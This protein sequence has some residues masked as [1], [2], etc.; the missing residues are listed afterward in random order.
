MS[1]MPDTSDNIDEKLAVIRHILLHG[2]R[3]R[4]E[5]LEN[6]I[7]DTNLLSEHVNPI[8]DNKITDIKNDFSN[9]FGTEVGLEFERKLL[10]SEDLLLTVLSPMMGKMIRK[11]ISIEIKKLQ[12]KID[13]QVK[14]SF[15]FKRYYHIIRAKVFGIESSALFLADLDDFKTKLQ[16]VFAIQISG[17]VIASARS[18]DSKSGDGDIFS[19]MLTAIKFFGEDSFKRK[20]GQKQELEFIEYESQKIF[21]QNHHNYYFAAVLNGSLNNSEKEKLASQLMEFADKEKKLNLPEISPE[22]CKYLSE[23]LK[24]AFF[25]LDKVAV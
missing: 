9:K 18:K 2:D 17:L 15:S 14:R 12:D 21:L 19:S 16:D 24:K 25:G 5:Q 13:Q 1:K 3:A 20:E 4:I 8:I 7:N 11:Y 6:I 10:M 22:D 23:Q